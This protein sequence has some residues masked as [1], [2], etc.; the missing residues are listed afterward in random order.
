M[1]IHV[2][3][4]MG[5]GQFDLGQAGEFKEKRFKDILLRPA[6]SAG[7]VKKMLQIPRKFLV[8][9]RRVYIFLISTLLVRSW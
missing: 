5:H 1:D 8:V 4:S 6:R 2:E 7:R 9:L 3:L